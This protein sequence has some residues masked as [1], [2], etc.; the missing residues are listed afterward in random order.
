MKNFVKKGELQLVNG[1]YLANKEGDAVSNAAFVQVQK[2]AEY[3]ITFAK[4]AKKKDFVGK[5][6]DT[7]IDLQQEVAKE[8]SKKETVFVTG[9]TKPE[10]E[11][12]AKLTLEA[13][14][15][16]TFKTD[17]TKT[18]KINKFLQSFEVLKEFEEFGLFFTEDVVKLNEI[19]TLEDVVDA[20]TQVID[21]LN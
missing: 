11:L 8:L 16:I 12:T 4:L 2:S 18:E 13:M 15:F 17:V 19:Y 1:G 9:P 3:V 21:L 5:T 14:S 7:L 20:V 6:A 10:G